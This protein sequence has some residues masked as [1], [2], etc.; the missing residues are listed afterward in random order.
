MGEGLLS[1][2]PKSMPGSL[3]S[4]MKAAST[5]DDRFRV[6]PWGP[7]S[8]VAVRT[9]RQAVSAVPLAASFTAPSTS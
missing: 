8:Y 9:G 6:H 1:T 7:S 3:I 4:L 2:L 5:A